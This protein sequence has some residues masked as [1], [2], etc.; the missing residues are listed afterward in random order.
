MA[1]G[2]SQLETF[3]MKLGRENSGP[4]RAIGTNVPGIQVSE[5]LPKMARQA[6]KLTIIR[7]MSTADP[8][9]AGG[10]YLMHTGYRKEATVTHPEIGGMVAKYLGDP[11]A[12]L[13]SFI[14]MGGGSGESS[15]VGGSG[16]LGP[17]YQPFK[18]GG[19]GAMPENTSPYVQA[20]A[21]QR[22]NDLLKFMDEE[23]ARDHQE[24]ALKAYREADEKSRRL[25][26]AKRTFDISAEWAKAKDRYGN[27]SFGRS[28]LMARRLIE[29]GVPFV[30]VGM[31]NWDSHWDHFEWSKALLPPMD[32]GWAA[33]LQDLS[34]RGLLRDT[35]VVW[36]GEFGRTPSINNRAGRDHYAKAWT[37]V[38][39]GGGVKGGYV[40]GATDEDGRAVTEK[41]VTTGD[42]FATIY[43]AL[44]MNPR[45]KHFVGT[46]PIWATPEDSTVV[47]DLLA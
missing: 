26:K 43:T 7:S 28:C 12:D 37:A 47:R 21:E 15:P 8:D 10:T 25:L 3:D 20:D 4:F 32:Q 45:V 42:L 16:Y 30:E 11:G 13:P 18:V 34:D 29:S 17:L 24:Q 2:V 46:R 9:H 22:R 6:D 35:L 38:L 5:Y 39:A 44:G 31:G 33:L 1:G 14:Q 23:F 19:E 40:H 36:M 27:S 41:P